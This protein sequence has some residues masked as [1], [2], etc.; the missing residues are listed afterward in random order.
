[1]T[2]LNG[3]I[4][5]TA[6]PRELA[7]PVLF[8]IRINNQHRELNLLGG[9]VVTLMGT[10]VS[11]AIEQLVG[12][13]DGTCLLAP[14]IN[15]GG[16]TGFMIFSICNASN[17]LP[18]NRHPCLIIAWKVAAHGLP[19]ILVHTMHISPNQVVMLV[20]SA[21]AERFF[22]GLENQLIESE[23]LQR[24]IKLNDQNSLSLTV[25]LRKGKEGEII[26]LE[27]LVTADPISPAVLASMIVNN[28]DQQSAPDS[29]E[30]TEEEIKSVAA[31][32]SSDNNINR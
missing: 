18:L 7:A 4:I 11:T 31:S 28:T 14:G 5:R 21:M 8:T 29:E 24:L 6:V 19:Q 26:G 23:T 25:H 32:T 15:S 3:T 16:I 1:L 2:R 12:G 27:V 20:E 17:N 10:L 22:N 13:Q 30:N 9:K